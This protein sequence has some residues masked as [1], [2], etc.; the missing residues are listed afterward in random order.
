[1]NP[2]DRLGHVAG[3]AVQYAPLKAALL[4][5][6]ALPALLLVPIVQPV[7]AAVDHEGLVTTDEYG[8]PHPDGLVLGGVQVQLHRPRKAQAGARSLVYLESSVG[9]GIPFSS[10]NS[11]NMQH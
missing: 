6:P 2:L 8:L 4:A 1:M 10:V 7:P 11:R 9:W 3:W 5:L